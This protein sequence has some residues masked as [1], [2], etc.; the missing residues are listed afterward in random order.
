[1]TIPQEGQ[2]P[3]CAHL[4]VE[5]RT[6][7]VEVTE[8]DAVRYAASHDP[9]SVYAS[10]RAGSFLTRGWWECRDCS[11]HFA[12]VVSS[13]ATATP[14]DANAIDDL[15]EGFQHACETVSIAYERGSQGDRA[16]AEKE[17]AILRNEIRRRLLSRSVSAPSEGL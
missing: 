12:P 1:M 7:P 6:E 5:Y 13:S 2:E 3:Q 11:R 15:I 8:A 14:P 17:R 10:P 16:R 4:C 9:A